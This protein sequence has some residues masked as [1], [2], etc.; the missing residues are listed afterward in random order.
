MALAPATASLHALRWHLWSAFATH[1]GELTADSSG[2]TC[3]MAMCCGARGKGGRQHKSGR[4]P[5]PKQ[6]A[7]AATGR[8][9]CAGMRHRR[10]EEKGLR[11]TSEIKHHRPR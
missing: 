8:M 10:A 4:W 2:S 5:K 11:S 7:N 1:H 3:T 6:S 9:M